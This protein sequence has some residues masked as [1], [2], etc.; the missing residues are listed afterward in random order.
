MCPY[1]NKRASLEGLETE[2]FKLVSS[3]ATT[4]QWKEWLRVPLEHA[5]GRGDL[6][7]FNKLLGAG[8]N[9][10]AGWRGCHGRTLLDAAVFGGNEGVVS[11]LLLAGAQPD[12]NV[13]SLSLGK[14][15]LYMAT[16]LGH[17]AVAKSLIVAGADVNFEDPVHQRSVLYAAVDGGRDRL[18]KDL[19]IG[20]A[21]LNAQ[22]DMLGRNL[23]HVA[24]SGGHD[25]IVSTLLVRGADKEAIDDD[26]NTPLMTASAVG[27]L[28]VV[29]T[30]LA[31]GADFTARDEA[32]FSALELAAQEGR[33]PVLQAILDHG[34]DVNDL[35]DHG[36]TALYTA[37]DH[38]QADSVDALVEAGALVEIENHDGCTPLVHA[39]SHCSSDGVLALLRH[40]AA[41]TARNDDGDTALHRACYRQTQ[42]L[43]ATVDLL[44]RWGADETAVNRDGKTPADMLNQQRGNRDVIERARLLLSRAPADR[45]W[46]R[47]GWLVM[48][49][50]RDST[51][52]DDTAGGGESEI[53]DQGVD[54]LSAAGA[55]GEGGDSDAPRSESGAGIEHDILGQPVPIGAAGAAGNA[56]GGAVVLVGAETK[57]TCITGDERLRV[58]L[59]PMMERGLEGVF[60]T[61]VSFV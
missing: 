59:R 19:V 9:G 48:L 22:G 56:N 11:G 21:D 12:V 25:G 30:L 17:G 55:D 32:G 13:V 2:I 6:E 34:A 50:S 42:A 4:E 43:E 8:A 18:V 15:A 33:V 51:T 10:S 31:A 60:R 28:C 41:V 26:G 27:S 52:N 44:L 53:C 7:L 36:Y 38:D 46:R 40:G 47:R 61:V 54:G 24:A 3:S 58:L 1:P 14:S 35:D 16:V 57:G 45:A 29:K 49:R 5:A 23:L 20:G 37:A 39:A